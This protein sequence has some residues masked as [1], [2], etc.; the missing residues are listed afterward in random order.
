MRSEAPAPR[1]AAAFTGTVPGE[2]REGRFTGPGNRTDA[3]GCR[4]ARGGAYPV[5][6]PVEGQVG[7]IAIVGHRALHHD[8][9]PVAA[10]HHA[11]RRG[12][13]QRTG[14]ARDA[15]VRRETNTR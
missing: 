4:L 9:R 10:P 15:C 13:K 6:D 1:A 8:V 11:I 12:P 14:E 7:E 3:L 5:R 2:V